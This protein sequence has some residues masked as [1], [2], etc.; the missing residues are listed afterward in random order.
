MNNPNK[1]R[2][3]RIEEHHRAAQALLVRIVHRMAPPQG[4]FSY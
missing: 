2:L 3:R 1:K 4:R